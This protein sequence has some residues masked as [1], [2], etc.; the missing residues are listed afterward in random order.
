MSPR[1]I[2]IVGA[3]LAGA[4][5]AEALRRQGFEDAIILIDRDLDV[6]YDRPPLSKEFLTADHEPVVRLWDDDQLTR[7]S[8]KL[9]LGTTVSSVDVARKRVVTTDGR[10]WHYWKL[11][12]ATGSEARRLDT[13]KGAHLGNVYYLRT[14]QDA[15]QLKRAIQDVERVVVIG[16]GFIGAE[17]AASLRQIGK[18]V[19]VVEILPR[20][21][22]R[23]WG[24]EAAEYLIWLHQQHGIEWRLG[25]KVLEFWGESRVTHVKTSDT[26]IECDAVIIGTGA[27]PAAPV[28]PGH[29]EKGYVVNEFGQTNI[30]DVYAA[31]DCTTWPY[32]GHAIHVEHWDH[33]KNHGRMAAENMIGS[34]PRP[35]R[36]VPY[37]WSD[38]YDTRLQY[39][40]YAPEWD[41]EVIRGEPQGGAGAIFYVKEGRVMAGLFINQSKGILAARRI[42]DRQ[43]VVPPERLGDPSIPLNEV[44]CEK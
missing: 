6:P 30:P 11:L 15:R 17:V 31:G 9:E 14:L 8:V 27:V 18:S 12:L 1:P 10:Q 24:T 33:A 25:Q 34:T 28:A 32:H 3:G 23:L 13:I 44:T 41:F 37:F 29:F 36:N 16:A 19:V 35:Y 38:Q 43:A 4:N 39:L 40:G 26:V 20:P 21:F 22:E 2:V 7:L 5:A 42:I